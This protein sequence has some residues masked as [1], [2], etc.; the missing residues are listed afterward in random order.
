[1]A[2]PSKI[3]YGPDH[4]DPSRSPSLMDF[5]LLSK[6]ANKLVY[7]HEETGAQLIMRGA[8]F[9]VEGDIVV[10]G[11]FDSWTQSFEGATTFKATSIGVDAAQVSHSSMMDFVN[12][13][14]VKLLNADNIVTSNAFSPTE[15]RYFGLR[16]NDVMYSGDDGNGLF[17]GAGK[18]S[19]FG[20]GGDDNLYGEGG[21]DRLSGGAGADTFMFKNGYGKD[22]VLDFDAIGG[23]GNQ[24]FIGANYAEVIVSGHGRD[25]IVD[26]GGGDTLTLI[27]VKAKYIDASDFR[28]FVI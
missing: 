20:Q 9:K 28:P 14:L 5:V 22:V 7:T 4:F 2:K 18:D 3:F 13:V 17:G 8:G 1:M 10:R 23:E 11:I 12:G 25:T 6:S 24:D 15:A 19:L 21:N 26:F 16:G 27:D